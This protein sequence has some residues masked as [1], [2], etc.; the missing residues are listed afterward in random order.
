MP[1]SIIKKRIIEGGGEAETV[2]TGAQGLVDGVHDQEEGRGQ[3]R[4]RCVT[5]GYRLGR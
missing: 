4:G 3:K 1:D 2:A 5:H